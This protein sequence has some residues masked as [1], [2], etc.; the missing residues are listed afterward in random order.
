[1]ETLTPS[2][3]SSSS[4]EWLS[5]HVSSVCASS[6]CIA[7]AVRAAAAAAVRCGCRQTSNFEGAR[8][9]RRSGSAVRQSGPNVH[10]LHLGGCCW[11]AM[12]TEVA[13]SAIVGSKFV[14]SSFAKR[15]V[16]KAL[17]STLGAPRPTH[18]RTEPEI[19]PLARNG[20]SI[21]NTKHVVAVAVRLSACNSP[22][23]L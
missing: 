3:I 8:V 19:L 2:G 20:P 22:Q 11:L 13:R 5:Q 16:R 18:S 4:S 7:V 12:S 9:A 17:S 6:M 15:G 10:V 14:G 23:L 21:T 1:M